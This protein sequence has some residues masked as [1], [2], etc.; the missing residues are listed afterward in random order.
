MSSNAYDNSFFD[1]N[2]RISADSARTIVPL[3]QSFLPG[4]TSAADFG[5]AR[6]IWLFVWNEFGVVNICGLDGDYIDKAKLHIS[7]DNFVTQDLSQPIRLNRRF[8]IIQSLEVAEHLPETA[9]VG[10]VKSL[11]KHSDVVLFS[12]AAPGQ[13]GA[14]H[15][16]E[17]PY[18]YWRDLFAN[19]RYSMFDCLRPQ[20]INNKN[21]Q[22]WYRFNTFLYVNE[23]K[24]EELSKDVRATQILPDMPIQDLSPLTYRIRKGVVNV[25]PEGVK[26]GLATAASK[27]RG[28]Q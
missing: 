14:H 2:D 28:Y 22:A 7:P 11:T 5:C 24:I 8:D 9:A 15:V 6:G 12:A 4:I 23:N 21:L 25:L 17:Q 20:I 27:W 26:N 18:S 16:N 13:G 19:E 3:I 1:Y 10:F